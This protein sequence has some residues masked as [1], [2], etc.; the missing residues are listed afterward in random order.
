MLDNG[1]DLAKV[2]QQGSFSDF[3]KAVVI[4]QFQLQQDQYNLQLQKQQA[5][6]LRQ[7]QQANS[8]KQKAFEYGV[9][10]RNAANLQINS[11]NELTT[12][13]NQISDYNINVANNTILAL[14]NSIIVDQNRA[15]K[16]AASRSGDVKTAYAASGIIVDSGTARDVSNQVLNETFS[17]AD[18]NMAQKVNKI[19]DI[20]G[21]ITNEK[22]N[23][24]F[25][26]ISA[27]QQVESINQRLANGGL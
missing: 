11:I 24:Y 26:Q 21:Q 15:N 20:L 3:R 16:V 8:Y 13:R 19:T 5:E 7:Q 12:L 1:I 6:A 22:L 17:E 23:N 14:Q 4:A 18:D 27:R 9:K 25:N 10:T 2:A